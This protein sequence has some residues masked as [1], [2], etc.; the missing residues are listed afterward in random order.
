MG[1]TDD[2]IAFVGTKKYFSFSCLSYPDGTIENRVE[3]TDLEFNEYLYKK[4]NK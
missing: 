4:F 1:A 2:F 3:I